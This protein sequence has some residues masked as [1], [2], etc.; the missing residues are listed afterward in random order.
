[1]LDAATTAQ[2]KTYLANLRTPVE[3]IATLDASPKSAE[4]RTLVETVVEQ[5]PLLSARYDGHADRV[6]SFAIRRADG[7]AE[8]HFAGL[9]LGHEF[10]SLVLALL[11]MGGHPPKEE[12]ELL[13]S[14]KALEGTF[15]FETFFSLS[16]QNCPDVIQAINIMAAL[17]PGVSHVA[18]DGALFREEVETRKVMAV[19]AVYLNGEPFGQ[20]RMDLSQIMA[21]LDTGT[22]A[23][24]AEK[25]AAKEP[26]EVLVVGGGPAGAAASIY[27][28]RKGIRTGVVA[29]RFGG[30]VLDTMGI[31]NF[32][33]V[34]HTEGPKLAAQ[35]EQH[36]RE[37]DVDIMNLQTATELIP[38]GADGLHEVKLASGASLKARTLIMSTG[39]RWRQMGVPGEEEYRNRGVAYCPHCDGPLYKGKRTAVIGGGN[40]GVEA[41][42][43]L[44]GIVAHVTLIEFD[45][46]LRA[47]AVLQKKLR[48]LP[49]VDIITS[50]LSTEVIGDGEKV[51]ALIYTDRNT[52][53]SHRID[54]DGI[55]V[56]IGLVP[57]TEWLK[58]PLTL[59][60]RGEIEIDAHNATNIPGVFAAGDVTT[61]PYKQIIVAMGEGTKAA[62]SAFDH[63]IRH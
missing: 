5:S 54:L 24:A 40:S 12:A 15:K 31:E 29:E 1:M 45:S 63:I 37:Y 50:A 14:V 18:I 26:F 61:V 43:D 46:Q 51:Q 25:I 38:A 62:L 58:G 53:E 35:L 7:T 21:K 32:I 19:P 56:Q 57:N 6:P 2:L 27:A 39:A 8:T 34:Q 28:A 33:S 55:F 42:I 11:H 60:P 47:D 48:S 49:N 4:M 13:D 36:V 10:T 22:I 9:P 52:D 59:S 16:C 30:Q 17:N 41:A 44:A 3:L 20:G 23:R